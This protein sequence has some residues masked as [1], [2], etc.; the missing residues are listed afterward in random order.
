MDYLGSPEAA[1]LDGGVGSCALF[2]QRCGTLLQ[3]LAD[4]LPQGLSGPGLR[5]EALAHLRADLEFPRAWN[6]VGTP[7][8]ERFGEHDAAYVG[9]VRG[10]DWAAPVPGNPVPHLGQRA[11][12]VR[13]PE[14]VPCQPQGKLQEPGEE[15]AT[16]DVVV[17]GI[18]LEEQQSA[19][20]ERLERGVGRRTPEVYL[21]S[22]EM[23]WLKPPLSAQKQPQCGERPKHCKYSQKQTQHSGFCFKSNSL[24]VVRSYGTL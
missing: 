9:I 14:R 24:I 11:H 20:L 16:G 1:R 19:G 7:T 17:G 21:R 6:R 23:L 5:I 4:G 2:H 10:A 8:E 3:P 13:F 15:P 18:E 22:K 12:A